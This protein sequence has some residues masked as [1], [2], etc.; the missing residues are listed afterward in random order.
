MDPSFYDAAEA[1]MDTTEERNI[2]SISA[3]PKRR[4]TLTS[5]NNKNTFKVAKELAALFE[6]EQNLAKLDADIAALEAKE[7]LKD[8]ARKEEH[9][10]MDPFEDEKQLAKLDAD[11]VAFEAKVRAKE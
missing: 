3:S 11:M 8:K 2:A 10:P 9:I 1:F 7:K 6:D 4:K 5:A